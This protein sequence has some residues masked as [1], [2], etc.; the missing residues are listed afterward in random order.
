[1]LPHYA[2][3]RRGFRACGHDQMAFRSPFGNLRGHA[4][5]RTCR[6]RKPEV[7]SLSVSMAAWFFQGVAPVGTKWLSGFCKMS[8]S[9]GAWLRRPGGQGGFRP[10]PYAP[11]DPLY[12]LQTAEGYP[13]PPLVPE[14]ARP[15]VTRPTGSASGT[16]LGLAWGQQPV[17]CRSGASALC[18]APMPGRVPLARWSLPWR[19]LADTPGMEPVHPGPGEGSAAPKATV[20]LP[21]TDVNPA[22]RAPA[23][24]AVHCCLAT[25][26]P[27]AATPH[28]PFGRPRRPLGTFPRGES[29]SSPPAGGRN[30]PQAT[31]SLLQQ[32]TTAHPSK[33]AAVSSPN[34][35]GV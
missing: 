32:K 34:D 10:H 23:R 22:G 8:F 30:L 31:I 5:W 7:S 3:G 21:G 16:P 20:A 28:A 15:L 29:T 19:P 4:C 6:L 2:C 33:N 18:M 1:M 27:G 11:L 17:G 25:G 35:C 14:G 9:F 26:G 24:L 13:R 12:P